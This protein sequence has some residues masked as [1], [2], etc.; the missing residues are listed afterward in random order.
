MIVSAFNRF[1]TTC[2]TPVLFIYILTMD[3]RDYAYF[4]ELILIGQRPSGIHSYNKPLIR[5][6]NIIRWLV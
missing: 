4:S 3:I 6:V 5:L 1:K 2:V